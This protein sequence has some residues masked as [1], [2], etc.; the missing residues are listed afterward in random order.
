MREFIN[1]FKRLLNNIIWDNHIITATFQLKLFNHIF[2][3]I[4]TEYFL[5]ISDI[6]IKYKKTA[7]QTELNI[8]L[9]NT[10][11]NIKRRNIINIKFSV[12]KHLKTSYYKTLNTNNKRKLNINL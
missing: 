4:I 9:L 5:K 1:E 12:R 8:I 7:L 11:R 6:Y 10:Q 3:K 2:N